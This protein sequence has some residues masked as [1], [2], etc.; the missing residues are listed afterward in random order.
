MIGKYLF[1]VLWCLAHNTLAHKSVED[2]DDG[3][4]LSR[5]NDLGLDKSGLKANYEK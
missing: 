3:Y 4:L 2:E 1:V 5:G